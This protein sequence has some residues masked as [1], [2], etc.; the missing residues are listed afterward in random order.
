MENKNN[1]I[2]WK[3]II[4]CFAPIVCIIILMFS[5]MF[6]INN[7][8]KI[9]E[10]VR[11][12]IHTIIYKIQHP[13]WR[14][15]EEERLAKYEEEIKQREAE[16]EIIRQNEI[17]E[18]S[19]Y[20]YP[21]IGLEYEY[22]EYTKLGSP[23]SIINNNIGARFDKEAIWYFEDSRYKYQCTA[24]IYNIYRKGRAPSGTK[25]VVD[26]F[27]VVGFE[28]GTNRRKLY[29]DGYLHDT[30]HFEDGGYLR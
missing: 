29:T 3:E 14:Q 15:E 21:P 13:N 16:R 11:T 23:D 20:S 9:Y 10:K 30:N 7:A 27:D 17:K 2:T 24:Y 25:Y 12:N 1:E 4:K 19:T 8:D 22:I 26:K 6:V 28:K 5:V 18:V